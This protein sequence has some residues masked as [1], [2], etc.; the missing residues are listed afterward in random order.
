MGW[1]RSLELGQQMDSA[2]HELDTQ[3]PQCLLGNPGMQL[4]DPVTPYLGR[5]ISRVPLV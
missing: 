1:S 5:G 3:E 2:S 4:V